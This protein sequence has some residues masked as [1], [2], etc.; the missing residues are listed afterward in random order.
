M[1]AAHLFKHPETRKMGQKS[2]DRHNSVI[3][4]E[5]EAYIG[6]ITVKFQRDE[7]KTTTYS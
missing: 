2:Y 7:N 5:K 4:K 1:I 6:P 3:G